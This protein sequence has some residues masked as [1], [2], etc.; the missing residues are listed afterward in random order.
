MTSPVLIG[1]GHVG[2]GLF[3]LL[4]E[5]VTDYAIFMLDPSGRVATWNVGAHRLKGYRADEILGRHFSVFYPVEEVARG[6]PRFELE[7][8][9]RVGRFEDE[10]WRIRKDGTRFWANVVITAMRDRE[11]ILRGF[12]KVTRDLSARKAVEEVERELAARRAVEA[13]R[14]RAAEE[15]RR[16]IAELRRAEEEARRIGEL[17][18]RFV[19]IVGHDLRTPLS[20]ISLGASTILHRGGLAPEQEATLGRITRSAQR[21]REII[22]DILD[23]VRARQGLGIPVVK[24]RA[25]LT[26][27][28]QRAMA[29]LGALSGGRPLTL[30]ARGDASLE[31]DPGRLLQV[32]SNL[33]GNAIQHGRGPVR[34]EVDGTGDE[35]RL[36]VHSH[37]SPIAPEARA[38]LFEPFR[39]G[40]REGGRGGGLGLGLF[41]VREVVRAHGGG[42][43]V[44]SGEGGT[45]FTVRLPRGDVA[46]QE[47]GAVP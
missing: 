27:I 45:T 24:G 39:R 17:Q 46:A 8:A 7:E 28:A 37:G 35:V 34:I 42:V 40:P 43:E 38:T 12:G 14:A 32:A 16:T 6:K 22:H 33:V 21:M 25:D 15:Q 44:E 20:V 2:D 23:V 13:E 10:G 9:T 4:V 26:E 36:S 41:I 5:C 19:A 11:G 29:E 1:E 31:G 3:R 18:E 30:D 47:L